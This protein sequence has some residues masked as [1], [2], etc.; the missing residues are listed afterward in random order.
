M[1]EPMEP[2]PSAPAEGRLPPALLALAYLLFAVAGLLVGVVCVTLIP[3][4]AGTALVPIAPVLALVAGVTLPA[5]SRGLTDSIASAAPAAI[6]Q[7]AGIWVL[8][9]GRPEG[10]V[11]MPAGSTASVSYAVLILGTLA[12]L[13]MLGLATRPGP[14]TFHTI[15][16]GALRPGRPASHRASS[17]ARSGSGSDGAR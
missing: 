7:V 10:D 3:L 1:S 4:R 14:W 15:R 13:F 11:L 16:H 17:A 12:P 9:T 5:V 8:S 2:V 6:G